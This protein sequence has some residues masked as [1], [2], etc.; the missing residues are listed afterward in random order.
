MRRVRVATVSLQYRGGPTVEANRAMI[1]DLLDQAVAERPDIVALPETFVSQGVKYTALEQIAE[2]IPGPTT[3]LV[4]AYARA[5]HCYILCPLIGDHGATAH[6]QFQNNA[7]LLDRQGEIVGIYAKIHPVVQGSEFKSL[8]LGITPGS[9]APVF[10]TDFGRIG[11]QICFDLMY[12]EAWLELKQQGAELVFWCSAYD[13]GKHLSIPAWLHHYY[14]VSSVQSRYSRAIGILGQTLAKTGW[15]DRVL[16]YT[17]D[18]DIGLF[19]LDFNGS[20]I[21]ALRK[22]YGPDINLD[23]WH[24]EGLFTLTTNR[25]DLS[26]ADIVHEFSLDPLDAYLDR[27]RTL[28]DAV[29]AGEPVP[30]LT[31]DYVGRPQWI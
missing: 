2:P 22:T 6:G 31:P 3:D 30:D 12:P 23:V 21:A 25:E 24:E 18:L 13:G 27:N 5:H 10:E 1:G 20:V 29:R 7:V 4:A 8:E 9:E 11:V 26:V 17:L 28:Q 19:H 14:I 16:A 15:H